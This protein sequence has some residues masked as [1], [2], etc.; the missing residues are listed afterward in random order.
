MV[1]PLQ[2]IFFQ[3]DIV[4][5]I[6]VVD[7][8]DVIA[9]REQPQGEMMADESGSAGDEDLHLF[10]GVRGEN[11]KAVGC[12]MQSISATHGRTNSAT[13]GLASSSPTSM[14]V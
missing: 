5:I 3:D 14:L 10:D 6:Q 8:D 1:Q 2:A 12:S 13:V 4:I 7:T 9:A 11:R